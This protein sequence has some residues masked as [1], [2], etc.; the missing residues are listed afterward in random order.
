MVIL[1]LIA[2][3]GWQAPAAFPD[4][5]E[6][7]RNLRRGVQLDY[8]LLRSYT[9]LERRR[10]VKISKLG[11]MNI[12]PL[13]TFEVYPDPSGRPYKR[14]IAIDGKPLSA[15]E[16]A[17]RDAEHERHLREAAERQRRESAHERT[18]R[19]NREAREQRERD[20]MLDDA[21]KVFEAT[22][23]GR[24]SVSGRSVLVA[25]LKP[26]PNAD[27]TTREGGWM[28][29]FE[30]EIQIDEET[31][32]VVSLDMRAI[33]DVTIGW[34]VI[35][36][37]HKGSRILVTRRWHERGWLPAETGYT[38]SGRTLLFRPFQFEAATTYSDFK[39]R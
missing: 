7:A 1:F 19:Q 4:R 23:T 38:A 30:G 31:W 2:L 32:Q 25:A 12:G 6:L 37:I 35:G 28:K 22:I 26:R 36:R 33:R 17:R 5:A 8:E 39:R 3:A 21:F 13:R 14:L 20:A 27:V 24:R 10:D 29:Q 9:Y 15:D 34:G 11:K 18:A 16:L